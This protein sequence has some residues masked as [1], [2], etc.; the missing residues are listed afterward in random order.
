MGVKA[1]GVVGLRTGN[2]ARVSFDARSHTGDPQSLIKM[3]TLLFLLYSHECQN[4]AENAQIV[5][6]SA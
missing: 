2:P 1:E 3:L 5:R 4:D 6:L